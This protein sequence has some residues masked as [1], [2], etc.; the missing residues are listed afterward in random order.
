[1]SSERDALPATTHCSQMRV[2][3][4]ENETFRRK[5]GTRRCRPAC[6]RIDRKLPARCL[7]AVAGRCS[8]TGRFLPGS[9]RLRPIA[10]FGNSDGDQAML[11]W[12]TGDKSRPHFGLLVHHTD[13]VREWAYD[14]ESKVGKLDKALD[15]ALAEGWTVMSMKDDWNKI[16]PFGSK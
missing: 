2:I 11:E 13:G 15:A 10:A 1:V 6:P 8:S 5:G 12:T 16:F 3:A 9:K 7:G 14:R 4:L